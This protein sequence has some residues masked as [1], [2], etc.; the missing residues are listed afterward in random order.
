MQRRHI[1]AFRQALPSV[2]QA[3]GTSAI[4]PAWV[5]AFT[6]YLTGRHGR[7]V[8]LISSGYLYLLLR[9]AFSALH[10]LAFACLEYA[11]T[12]APVLPLNRALRWLELLSPF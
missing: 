1:A 8:T 11:C 5:H 12:P 10:F 6:A 2:L 4:S 7:H 9:R 3:Y